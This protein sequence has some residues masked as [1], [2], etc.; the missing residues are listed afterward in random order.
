MRK[1]IRTGFFV[2]FTAVLIIVLMSLVLAAKTTEIDVQTVR[3]VKVS[4]FIYDSATKPSPLL[5]SYHIQTSDGRVN[6]NYTGEEDKIDI[7]VQVT[8]NGQQIMLERFDDTTAGERVILSVYPTNITRSY[9]T[10]QVISSNN[11]SAPVNTSNLNN[12]IQNTTSTAS[13][14][15]NSTNNSSSF[16]SISSVKNA[17]LSKTGIYT[18]AGIIAAIIAIFVIRFIIR[19]SPRTK[20]MK[21]T[22]TP[23]VHQQVQSPDIKEA[24]SKLEETQKRLAEAQ[25][26]IARLKNEERIKEIQKR[27]EQEKQEISKLRSGNS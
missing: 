3:G 5:N 6:V 17:I 1:D 7:K 21:I 10:G 19:K 23:Q 24:K 20:E 4:L 2:M 8:E 26:E 11:S 25:R 14:N 27:I 18:I 22:K 16:I 13:S 9:L 12:I 15:L